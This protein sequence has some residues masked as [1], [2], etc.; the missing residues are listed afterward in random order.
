MPQPYW[1]ETNKILE[2]KRDDLGRLIRFLTGHNFTRRH[3]TVVH[4][5]TQAAG[6]CRFCTSQNVEEDPFHII[7]RCPQFNRLR[8]KIFGKEILTWE[9]LSWKVIHEFISKTEI[10]GLEENIED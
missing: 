4:K 3:N 10:S 9:I 8:K 1:E 7:K 5:L 6:W 2:L